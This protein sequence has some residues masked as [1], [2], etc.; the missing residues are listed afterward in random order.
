MAK[1]RFRDNFTNH[2]KER[3]GDDRGVEVEPEVIDVKEVRREH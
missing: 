1:E 3:R 2:Q